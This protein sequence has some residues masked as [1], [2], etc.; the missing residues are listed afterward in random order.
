LAT[1]SVFGASNPVAG[2]RKATGGAFSGRMGAA[3]QRSLWAGAHGALRDLTCG[4]LSE[5]SERSERSELCRT[6]Q[7][8][9]AQGSLAAGEAKPS[10]PR[11]R[12]ARRLAR[13][14]VRMRI[15]SNFRFGPTADGGFMCR[16]SRDVRWSN[17]HAS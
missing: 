12:P 11:E 10:E 17:R 5:R 4:T 6:A 2:C 8:R 1:E 7:R 16:V 14:S 13:A 3:E 15:F 9:V